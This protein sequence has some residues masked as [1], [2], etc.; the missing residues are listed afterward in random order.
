MKGHL[1]CTQKIP[2]KLPVAESNFVSEVDVVSQSS[3]FP[4]R[5]FS[6]V[7]LGSNELDGVET[8]LS[9]S[10]PFATD[11]SPFNECI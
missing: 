6:G 1:Y 3:P 2:W 10:L 4:D 11:V 7:L 8:E 5:E 9:D